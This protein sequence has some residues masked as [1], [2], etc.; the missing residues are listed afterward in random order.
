L[1]TH[2]RQPTTLPRL[3]LRNKPYTSQEQTALEKLSGT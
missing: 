2:L 1:A 3:A